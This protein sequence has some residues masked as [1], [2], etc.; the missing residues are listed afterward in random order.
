MANKSYFVALNTFFVKKILLTLFFAFAAIS[1]QAQTYCTPSYSTGC[2]VNDDIDDV[3]IGSFQDTNTGCSTNNYMVSTGD[4]VDI[5]RGGFTT[6]RFTSNYFTQYFA[7]WVDFNEDGDFDDAY[8]HLWSS[9]TNNWSSNVDSIMVPPVAAL[10]TYRMRIRSNFS[11][12]I[13]ASESCSNFTYGEV[14]DYTARVVDAPGCALPYFGGIAST[15][16]S[17]TLN[18]LSN[19]TSFVVEYGTAGFAPGLG[20]LAYTNDTTMTIQ[21]LSSNTAYEFYVKTN[22]TGANN[23]YSSNIGPFYIKTLCVPA[24]TPIFE[25]FENDSL[26]SFNNPNAPSCWFYT[27]DPSAAGYGYI[28]GG[29]TWSLT[30]K[31]GNQLYYLYN[32]FDTLREILVSPSVLGLDSGTKKIEFYAGST[33]NTSGEVVIGTMSDPNDASTFEVI[34]SIS[35]TGGATWNKYTSY[36]YASAGYNMSDKHIAIASSSSNTFSAIYLDDITID[37]GP[38][39]L[40]PSAISVGSIGLDSAEIFFSTTGIASWLEYGPVGFVPNFSQ[41]TGTLVSASGS[42][43][44]LTG[45]DS[46]TSYDV[47]VYQMCADSSI[48]PAFGPVSFKTL[49][50]PTYL[51]CTLDLELVDSF[52]DGWNG[53]EVQVINSS[54][55]VEYTFGSDF[56]TGSSYTETM[57]LCSGGSYSI[58]V[59]DAGFYSN[60]IGVNLFKGSS[61]IASYAPNTS[62]AQGTVMT[63]FVTSCNTLCPDPSDLVATPTMNG[64][65]FTFNTNGN[66]GTFDYAWGPTGWSQGTGAIAAGTGNTTTNGMTINGLTPGTCYDMVVIANCGTNGVSDTLGPLTFCTPLCPASDLCTY[67]AILEDSYGDG[68]NGASLTYSVNGWPSNEYFTFSSGYSDTVVIT[69]CSGSFV[70]F[71]NGTAGSYPSEVSYSVSSDYSGSVVASVSQ[72]GFTAGQSGGSVLAN[73]VSSVCSVPTNLA[74]ASK[75]GSNATI[76]WSG[77]ASNYVF[78]F[79]EQ[80]TTNMLTGTSTVSSTNLSG[81]GYSRYYDFWVAQVCAPGDTSAFHYF[82]FESDSCA[83]VSLGTPSSSV[84]NVTSNY[85]EVNFDWTSASNYTSYALN[86]GDGNSTTGT[87][88]TALHQ[89]ASNGTFNAVLTLYGDCDTVA[90][91]ITV[92]VSGIGLEEHIGLDALTLYPNPTSGLITIDAAVDQSTVLHVRVINYLGGVLFED[93]LEASSGRLVRTYD[94]SAQASGAYVI[95]IQTDRGMIQKSVIVRH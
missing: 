32:S 57:T 13:Q 93:H 7:I 47:Y 41:G 55:N 31:T 25:G 29:A 6:V 21:N 48:S 3:F 65:S 75:S 78:K 12:I 44:W 51:M 90:Q 52:G 76:S 46:N 18:W 81:L 70:E 34:D 77:S 8:E 20:T 66:T 4:T 10:G 30:P 9:S 82:S 91:S 16:S 64:A 56:T 2:A 59:S 89:Y 1:A 19:D 62:T 43:S 72:G 11:G 85:A 14:H 26:G 27:E 67:T 17:V 36:I 95:E 23:G 42:P 84:T 50:C 74:V 69:V 86:F 38:Q 22:C 68:W 39:C 33:S 58:V 28:N 24:A 61:L 60:E 71:F 37:N 54:G 87:G 88:T 49:T 92:S 15:D 40:P 45:L 63:T 83:S 5:A 80:G 53:A 73:C 79:Q 35:V 94:L